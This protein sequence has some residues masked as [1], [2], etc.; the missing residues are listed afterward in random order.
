MFYKTFEELNIKIDYGVGGFQLRSESSTSS[1]T[2]ASGGISWDWG[3]ILNST[4]LE[5]IS[6]KGSNGRLGTWS[7]GLGGDSSSSS[8]LD[9]NGVDSDILEEL[10]NVHSG[11][12]G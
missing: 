6:G 2:S 8:E 4:D 7:W 3:N 12:H 10:D 11:E 9:V 5:S 1:T